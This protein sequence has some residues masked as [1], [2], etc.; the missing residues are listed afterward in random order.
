MKALPLLMAAALPAAAEVAAVVHPEEMLPSARTVVWTPLFQAS[1]DKLNAHHG[2]KPVKVEP[3][4]ALISRLD[5][6]AWN[7]EAV[8]PEG[9]WKT[10]SGPAS[11]EF[12]KTVNGEAA[13]MTGEAEGPFRLGAGR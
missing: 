1:W 3:P 13:A 12:L 11:E 4:N 5:A 9:R 8:M 10:W 6:F 7:P 2:G